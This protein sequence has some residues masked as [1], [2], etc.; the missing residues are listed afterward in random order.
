MFF[1]PDSTTDYLNKLA[2]G[3]N[4]N[5]G[6]VNCAHCAL[7]FDEHLAAG[8]N[9]ALGAVPKEKA[10]LYTHPLFKNQ[11]IIRSTS[12][13]PRLSLR[14][15]QPSHNYRT[16]CDLDNTESFIV[17]LT[18]EDANT[19]NTQTRLLR[20]SN[21]ELK[22]QL[23]QLP[24]RANDGTAYGFIFLSHANNNG[25]GHLINFYITQQN[26]VY[27]IDSQRPENMQVSRRLSLEGYKQDI[28]YVQSF[29]P[30]GFVVKKE[31]DFEPK[32]KEEPIENL[33]QAYLDA[34][35]FNQAFNAVTA[36]EK[37]SNE[38][39]NL[40][41]CYETG[42]G[43]EINHAE[44][45]KCYENAIAAYDKNSMAWLRLGWCYRDGIGT[46]A[47]A[48]IAF[49]CYQKAEKHDEKNLLAQLSL[50]NCYEK[51]L[52]TLPHANAAFNCY[53]SM[54]RIDPKN[55]DALAG[56]GW[57]YYLG[58][59]TQVSKHTALD[60]FEKALKINDRH[61]KALH[62]LGFHHEHGR[63][64]SYEKAFEYYQK[65]VAA[66]EN[67]TLWY[68][69][70]LFYE[71]G[72]GTKVNDKSAFECYL[73][74]LSVDARDTTTLFKLGMCYKLGKGTAV[75]HQKA[76]DCFKKAHN[77][78]PFKFDVH[79]LN[80]EKSELTLPAQGNDVTPPTIFAPKV[81]PLPQKNDQQ[82]IE[83]LKKLLE[84][85]EKEISE[86]K[87][88]FEG[89]PMG[90]EDEPPAKRYKSKF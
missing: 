7:R 85:K 34:E 70:G 53:L 87:R 11:R 58:K 32:I 2:K 12:E 21:E 1:G 4:G 16:I 15:N 28:F 37:N 50:A 19:P 73:R 67:S 60:R 48:E 89:E 43:T 83:E 59:G 75:N 61:S 54:K 8:R 71:E 51:G 72:K 57:C 81:K 41:I 65:A 84:T 45:F 24:K 88:K 22:W 38:W 29:P 39:V 27:F 62:G 55:A 13:D 10:N 64:K 9:L 42:T 3:I 26:E 56:L 69:L 17:D 66:D 46:E 86:L 77:Y 52:G 33:S 82:E 74:A 78:D 5:Q 30:E 49:E 44:A 80:K 79:W 31:L 36:N 90:A 14:V 68:T 6:T 63:T 40:G 76:L 20:T 35:K 47:S 18:E 23:Q 25:I